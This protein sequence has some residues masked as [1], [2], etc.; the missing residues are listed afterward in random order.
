MLDDRLEKLMIGFFFR[1][2]V[3]EFFTDQLERI[4]SISKDLPFLPE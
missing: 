4:R 2:D 3:S 1:P